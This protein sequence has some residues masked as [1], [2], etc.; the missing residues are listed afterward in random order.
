MLFRKF[1]GKNIK[2]FDYNEK[3]NEKISVII[4]C[5][6]ANN[7]VWKNLKY[8]IKVL[9]KEFLKIEILILAKSEIIYN[10]LKKKNNIK[11]LANCKII[12]PNK[13][14]LSYDQI[15][16]WGILQTNGKI[17]SIVDSIKNIDP[18]TII[19]YLWYL[20][21]NKKELLISSKYHKESSSYNFVSTSWKHKCLG[22]IQKFLFTK[23]N[24]PNCIDLQPDV[25]CFSNKF[26]SKFLSQNNFNIFNNLNIL[27]LINYQKCNYSILPICL[28]RKNKEN[29]ISSSQT[30]MN[31]INVYR[32]FSIISTS[33]FSYINNF[34]QKLEFFTKSIIFGIV[35]IPF[36]FLYETILEIKKA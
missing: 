15:L 6:S 27:N 16:T 13:K 21:E 3:N 22:L 17:V 33:N 20:E 1:V 30:L 14:N 8:I 19:E 23:Q 10:E 5:H 12:H 24:L 35:L 29:Y 11:L 2:D 28:Y 32:Y 34:R 4:M 18:Y 9:E 25:L 26:K 36:E 7:E 31:I